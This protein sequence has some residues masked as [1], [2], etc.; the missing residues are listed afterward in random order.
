LVVTMRQKCANHDAHEKLLRKDWKRY[1]SPVVIPRATAWGEMAI[2]GAA[3][4]R[5][6]VPAKAAAAL[7]EDITKAIKRR[8]AA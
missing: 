6:S 5:N 7:W 4:K 3:W 1:V 8:A 2:H